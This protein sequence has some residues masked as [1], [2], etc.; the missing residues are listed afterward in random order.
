MTG[1]PLA[2]KYLIGGNLE[3]TPVDHCQS[4]RSDQPVERPSADDKDVLHNLFAWRD[5]SID[6]M[7]GEFRQFQ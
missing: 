4:R 1:H 7:P 5:R 2:L 3:I 6:V